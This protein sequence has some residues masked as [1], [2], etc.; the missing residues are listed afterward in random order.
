M[1]KSK[2]LLAAVAAGIVGL[3]APMSLAQSGAAGS[4]QYAAGLL[5]KLEQQGYDTAGFENLTLAQIAMIEQLLDNDG[6]RNAVQGILNGVCG[7]S[8]LSGGEAAPKN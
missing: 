6:S 8:S 2:F 7:Q 4:G 5:L 3:A 1:M